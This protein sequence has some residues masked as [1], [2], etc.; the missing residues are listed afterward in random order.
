MPTPPADIWYQFPVIAILAITTLLI[1]G[2]FYKLW[3]DLL[4]WQDR[5]EK[6]RAAERALQ[7]AKRDDEREKQRQWES[8][9]A[10]AR[11]LQWQN[12]LRTQQEQWVANDRRNS[13]VLERL[14]SRIDDL[15]VSINSHD[16]FVRASSGAVDRPTA[17]R[18]RSDL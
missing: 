6:A 2:A 17:R 15:A 14:V 8:E 3:N 13:A 5:Q 10:R 9:Q 16:T 1:A 11:D 18:T 7:D 12:F 4:S